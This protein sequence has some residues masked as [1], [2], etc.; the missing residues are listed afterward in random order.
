MIENL[1]VIV[2][3]EKI[4]IPKGLTLLE[5]SK[6][7]EQDYTYPI[8]LAKV[9]GSYSELTEEINKP[10]YIEFFDLKDRMANRA[11]VSGLVFLLVT[12]I[13]DL[14]GEEKNITVEHSLDKGLYITTNFPILE[15]DMKNIE[16]RMRELVEQDL[17]IAKVN[18]SRMD[19]I[20]Y[21][22]RQNDESKLGL[23]KY[24]TRSTVTL[25]RLK[26]RYDYFF[27]YMPVSTSSL[28][29][30]ALTYFDENSF[31]LR[32]MTVY[33]ENEISEY[34]KR[35]NIYQIYK[36]YREWTEL[37]HLK[38]VSDLNDVISKG[39]IGDLIRMDEIMQNGKLLKV[40]KEIASRKDKVKIVL[41]AGPSSSGKTTTCTKLK[42]C[43]QSLGLNPKMISMDNYFVEREETPLLPN[44][45]PD[46]ECLE[47][48]DLD[49][50]DEQIGKLFNQEEVVI[51]TY[52][53]YIGKKEYKSK[54]K[55]EEN[56]I[57]MI[58]GI[59]GLN[60]R[61]L[62][63]IPKENKYRIYL[64]ALAELNLD[65]HNRISTADNRLLR[66]IVRDYRTRGYSVEAT[67][68]NWP[69]VRM[70]EEKYIF[71]YQDEADATFNTAL[72][73]ELSI[74][75]TYVEPLLYS[76]NVNSEYYDEAKRLINFL[77]SFLPI[78]SE[79]IPKESI[80]REFIGGSCFH[81]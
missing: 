55:L 29:P 51:P 30:F 8:I 25:Y 46:Y 65:Q 40:A 6:S 79:D 66:R 21:F 43:L 60:N 49:L 34:T 20:N 3:D 13:K 38:N 52:N 23:Y 33:M 16:N 81:Q 18:V 53:F 24:M 7:F 26:N 45:K 39:K 10:C 47:A 31:L 63:N 59:H 27:T 48:I 22:T 73:Y 61:I 75:K 9:D 36:E 14:Y 57:L 19:A 71:P 62:E 54:M 80:I 72:I 2:N 77:R 5:I 58:E 11:Y 32:F 17:D 69:T 12:V 37:L 42:M 1:T 70:G 64:S 44:G 28:T 67:L 35:E 50:F 68:K 78:P 76:V 41:I 15:N 4:E 56:D 74:L